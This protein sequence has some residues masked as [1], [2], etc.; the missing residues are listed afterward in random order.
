MMQQQRQPTAASTASVTATQATAST[1]VPYTAPGSPAIRPDTRARRTAGTRVSWGPARAD[2]C[3]CG[4]PAV[5]DTPRAG[6]AGSLSQL[7]ELCYGTEYVPRPR[8]AGGSRARSLR[9]IASLG[10]SLR[11]APRNRS[12]AYS[13]TR[14]FRS[15]P[16]H[17]RAR[18][19]LRPAYFAS[20]TQ[21]CT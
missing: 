13:C 4:R 18:A 3:T 15:D 1:H 12:H 7:P 14:D 16:R 5:A 9:A 6:H 2:V 21:K 17:G 19:I 8:A 20:Q 10:A 11:H